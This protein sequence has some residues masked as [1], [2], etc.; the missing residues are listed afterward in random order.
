MLL[1]IALAAWQLVTAGAGLKAAQTAAWLLP[2]AYCLLAVSFILNA[3]TPV[4]LAALANF[5]MLV[6]YWPLAAAL[7]RFA[8]PSNVQYVARCGLAGSI[9]AAAVAVYQVHFTGLPRATGFFSD[10]I[11]S[12]DAAVVLGFLTFIGVFTA[13]GWWKA[14][15][16]LGPLLAVLVVVLSGSRGPL[17]AVPFL[18]LITSTLA[19]KRWYVALLLGCGATAALAVTTVLFW[20]EGIARLT[21]LVTMSNEVAGGGTVS[22]QSAS[23]RLALLRGAWQAFWSSPLLGHGWAHFGDVIAPYVGEFDLA[24]SE[25]QFHLHNDLANFAVGAGILGILAYFGILI[26]PLAGALLS[27]RDSQFGARIT[28]TALLGGGY[29][30]CGLTNTL[31]GFE[32]LTTLYVALAA[33]LLAFCRDAPE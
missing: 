26:A 8:M 21:S 24:Q 28:G 17:L 13:G 7:R 3:R 11:W 9:I 2:A 19:F 10:S 5:V 18:I 22:E 31:F 14:A 33:I 4:D 6:L 16:A 32:F 20:P 29:F 30:I 25:H 23:I 27:P 12:A 15:F 1:A